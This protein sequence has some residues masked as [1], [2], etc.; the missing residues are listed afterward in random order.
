M[1]N[2][3]SIKVEESLKLNEIY[4][5]L[6][7][8]PYKHLFTVLQNL[9]QFN[10]NKRWSAKTCLKSPLFDAYRSKLEKD[11]PYKIKLPIFDDGAFNYETGYSDK[12][13]LVD[14]QDILIDE[15]LVIKNMD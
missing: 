12:Y 2:I 6:A 9:L 8:G 10:P 11:A 1:K 14:F 4:K 5:D 3:E 15:I 7:N 13:S